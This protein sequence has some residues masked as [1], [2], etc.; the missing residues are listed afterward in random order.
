MGLFSKLFGASE[1]K[2]DF[3]TLLKNGSKV[4]DV[5]SVGEFKAGHFKGSLNY[6]LDGLGKEIKTISKFKQPLIIVC[7]S[8]GRA[9]VA[10]KELTKAGIECYNAGGWQNL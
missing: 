5:R 8:G 4:I 2:A 7:Q 9:T 6:P 1:P 10:K 3:D